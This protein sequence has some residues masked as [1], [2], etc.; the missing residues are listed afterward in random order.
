MIV[1]LTRGRL[2]VGKAD[3]IEAARRSIAIQS[4]VHL[5][6]FLAPDLL[7]D[8]RRQVAT[9]AFSTRV[10][11]G[12]SVGTMPVD[13]EPDASEGLLGR[14]SFLFNDP[15]LFQFVEGLT[16][17]DPI[18]FFRPRVFRMLAREGHVDEWHS[19]VDDNRMVVLSVNLTE[20][21][22]TGGVLTI[23]DAA[24]RRTLFELANTG[25]GDAV[26]F[27]VS[28]RFQHKVTD[29]VGNVPRVVLAGWFQRE[30]QYA[31]VMPRIPVVPRR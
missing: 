25:A 29:V 23:R 19:D 12:V 28:R 8:I 3:E 30:P 26:L 6:G 13:E 10:H 20:R 16:G 7:Q 27:L 22:F 17:C 9:A 21:P 1:R 11:D 15:A 18:G 4:A 5:E 14:I 24:D 31:T 2:E